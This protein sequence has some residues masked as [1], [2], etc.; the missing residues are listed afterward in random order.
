MNMGKQDE[1]LFCEGA[2]GRIGL[3]LPEDPLVRDIGT[4]WGLPVGQRVRITFHPG[5]SFRELTGRLEVA[6]APELPLNRHRSLRLR[7][8]GYDFVH[9]TVAG[10]VVVEAG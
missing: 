8:A 3:P 6:V 2:E 1:F 9:T 10:C 5:E 4:E 7:I